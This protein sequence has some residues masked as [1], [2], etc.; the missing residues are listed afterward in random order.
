[1]VRPSTPLRVAAAVTA[2][3]VVEVEEVGVEE[4][5]MEAHL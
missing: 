1:M 2:V 5:Q 3:Q 4:L